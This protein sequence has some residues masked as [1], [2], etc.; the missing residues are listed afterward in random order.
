MRLLKASISKLVNIQ[1]LLA[2][3][4]AQ[5][6]IHNMLSPKG[7]SQSILPEY[8]IQQLELG[9]QMCYLASFY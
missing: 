5:H 9:V 2:C 1:L 8:E 4:A 6:P 3:G 7:V